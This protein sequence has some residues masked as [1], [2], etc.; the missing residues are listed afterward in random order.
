MRQF[1]FSQSEDSK[2][3]LGFQRSDMGIV[4]VVADYNVYNGHFLPLDRFGR[5]R[6]SNRRLVV[7]I[8]DLL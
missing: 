1:K 5:M 6:S 4:T 8:V 2:T 7:D 3:R